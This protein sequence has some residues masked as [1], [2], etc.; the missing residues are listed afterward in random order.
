MIGGRE[1]HGNAS[2]KSA[3]G[4][5]IL[6]ESAFDTSRRTTRSVAR[7]KEVHGRQVTV[8]DTPGWWLHYPRENTPELDKI[9]IENSVH[10][11]HPGPNAFL[12]VIPAGV[13][14]HQV[15]KS[16]LEEHL[17]LFPKGVL[18]RTIVLFT[19]KAKRG[20][21][22]LEEEISIWPALQWIINQCGNRKHVLNVNKTQKSAQVIKLF[23]KID[24]MVEENSG[25]YFSVD[26]AA[27]EALSEKMQAIVKR[28]STRCDEVKTQRGKLKALIEGKS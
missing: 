24:A 11:C 13:G 14:F 28:A 26:R 7:Q 16:S 2:K 15:F 20:N 3:S 19:V 12:L 5:I 6:G 17:K 4:N 22:S 21:K 27:G 9:E 25:S 1:I 23:E 8:V 10:L 18:D